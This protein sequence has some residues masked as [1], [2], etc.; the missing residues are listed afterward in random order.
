MNDTEEL[1]SNI[2]NTLVKIRYPKITTTVAQNVY[3]MILSG[4]SRISLLSW[5][6]TEKSPE[7]A[8]RLQKLKGDVLEGIFY[9]INKQIHYIL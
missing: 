6:L 8:T 7:T 5:L 4:E 3:S 1:M 2:Y 9:I